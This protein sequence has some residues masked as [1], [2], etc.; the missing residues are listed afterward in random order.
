MTKTDG[1]GAAAP[2]AWRLVPWLVWGVGLAAWTVALLVPDPARLSEGLIPPE[3]TFPVAKTTHVLAYAALAALLAWL[4]VRPR[5]R[6]W[7]LAGLA[8]H[9]CATE[10]LQP[11]VG[12]GGSFTDVLLDHAGLGLGLAVSWAWWRRYPPERRPSPPRA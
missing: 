10:A 6:W 11:Y 4:P 5:S 3:A 9:G 12:R 8:L 1:P 7:L 2:S